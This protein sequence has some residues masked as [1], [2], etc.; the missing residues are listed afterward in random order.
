[1]MLSPN[2]RLLPD[3][4]ITEQYRQGVSARERC[5]SDILIEILNEEQG[6]KKLVDRFEGRY[7]RG[8]VSKYLKE[9][10]KENMVSYRNN[11]VEFGKL[12]R[13]YCLTDKGKKE[14][15]KQ[16]LMRD[17]QTLSPDI[18]KDFILNIKLKSMS[19][20]IGDLVSEDESIWTIEKIIPINYEVVGLRDKEKAKLII[21]IIE[22]ELMRIG[23]SNDEIYKLWLLG[24]GV[25]ITSAL[26]CF[27]SDNFFKQL[28]FKTRREE[29]S[30]SE[31]R[32]V[33]KH[34]QEAFEMYDYG[35]LPHILKDDNEEHISAFH[36][37]HCGK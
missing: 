28:P 9:L 5:P 4:R 11:N 21:R 7:A 3:K 31:K 2:K 6:F 34:I 20:W 15:E 36:E 14:A 37:N 30:E 8:T 16:S 29:Y 23:Y 10:L 25:G 35:M 24:N 1:M 33:N 26:Q 18:L 22:K 17:L 13:P 32:Y 12:E 27:G 19:S